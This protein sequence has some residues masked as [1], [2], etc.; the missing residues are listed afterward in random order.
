MSKGLGLIHSV[1]FRDSA[2]LMGAHLSEVTTLPAAKTWQ[3][4]EILD[5]GAEGSC[6]GT[7]GRHGRT[8]SRQAT[9]SSRTTLSPWAGT[10]E[11][12]R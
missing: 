7:A 2:H 3:I 10:K 4:G 1:D 6:V 5:Q 8:R 11:R 9:P 12:R